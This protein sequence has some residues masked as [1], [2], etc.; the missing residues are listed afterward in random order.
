MHRVAQMRDHMVPS[1]EI[2]FR[3]LARQQFDDRA[4]RDCVHNSN[5]AS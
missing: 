3:Q 2:H 5:L 1:V 4:F